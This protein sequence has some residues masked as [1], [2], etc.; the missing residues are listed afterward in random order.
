MRKYFIILL[1]A[2][3]VCA[4][5]GVYIFNSGMHRQYVHKLLSAF[6][7]TEKI[8]RFIAE[9]LSRDTYIS[10]MSQYLPYHRAAEFKEINRRLMLKEYEEA[11]GIMVKY[12]LSNGWIQ[13]SL[14]LE[15]FAG[16]N[17]KS[18]L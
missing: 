7:G 18:I 16:V 12:G 6:F 11:K 1:A 14:G 3:I 2:V 9:D 15:R 17:I 8:M 5:G 4:G 13:E 10:L